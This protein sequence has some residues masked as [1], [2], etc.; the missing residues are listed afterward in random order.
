MAHLGEKLHELLLIQVPLPSSIDHSNHLNSVVQTVSV[1]LLSQQRVE[2]LT[3]KFGLPLAE[4]AEYIMQLLF[5]YMLMRTD[6]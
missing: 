2:L 5:V 4:G 1:A 6:Q 3:F